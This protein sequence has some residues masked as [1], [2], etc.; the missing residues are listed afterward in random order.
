MSELSNSNMSRSGIPKSWL[1]SDTSPQASA[2]SVLLCSDLLALASSVLLSRSVLQEPTDI[3]AVLQMV[4][5]LTFVLGLALLDMY[6]GRGI[7][8]P[9]R[10]RIRALMVFIA[11]FSPSIAGV[12]LHPA[13]LGNAVSLCILTGAALFF[14]SSFMELIAIRIA[15]GLGFWRSQAALIGDQT[16]CERVRRELSIYPELGWGL[17]DAHSFSKGETSLQA[18]NLLHQADQE[19]IFL[20]DGS[21][22]VPTYYRTN[23][24]SARRQL[25][26]QNI[27]AKALKR[28]IDIIGASA[29]LCLLAPVLVVVGL[30]IWLAD[31]API[32]FRQVRGGY[33]GE[34]FQVLKFR[35]M[36]RDAATRLKTMLAN[37]CARRKEWE[38]Y[39]KLDRDPRILPK[40]GTIIRVSSLDELP[41]LL[42]VLKGDMSLVGPRPFPEDHLAV[43]AP[44]FQKLRSSVMPGLSG[45]WQV[46]LRSNGDVNDQEC[47]DRTYIEGWSLWLDLYVIF[48]TPIALF[49]TKGA[50]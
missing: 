27:L 10:I 1:V 36:Y 47:L 24:P 29:A 30:C 42:N 23:F 8:G 48:L 19:N 12:L 9:V 25:G 14:L 4:G 28:V 40:I 32:F 45:L 50:R 31:G 46:T 11:F 7:W 35:S 13:E 3:G 49:S 39:F 15:D 16:L 41:Q 33:L 22:T 43:F 26:P 34:K 2:V 5:G 38:Q 6:P 44:E 21:A 37:D 17:V 18:T 20:F